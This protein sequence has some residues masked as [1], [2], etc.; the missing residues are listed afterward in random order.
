VTSWLPLGELRPDARVCLLCLPHAGGRAHAYASWRQSAPADVDVCPVEL[1]G[2][3]TRYAER[4]LSSI[5][6]LASAAAV[7]L[8]PR[9]GQDLVLF[10]HSMGA[11]VAFETARELRDLHGVDVRHLFVAAERAPQLSAR[12]VLHALPGPVFRQKVS[13][14]GG[15]PPEVLANDELFAAVEPLLRTDLAACETYA[16]VGGAQLSC[17]IT[18]YAGSV[19]KTLRREELEAWREQTTGPFELHVL[20]GDHFF[21]RTAEAQ[22][23]GS[24]LASV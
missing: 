17:P 14:L 20:P 12:A 4:A 9:A 3:G 24:V 8:R 15:T 11:L 19:D 2:H 21:P 7:A 1:P 18:V 22:L 10:G 6:A 5:P 23:L 13:E 16:Y